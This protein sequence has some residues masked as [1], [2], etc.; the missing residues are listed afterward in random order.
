M[1]SCG[2]SDVCDDVESMDNLL[3]ILENMSLEELKAERSLERRNILPPPGPGAADTFWG[4]SSGVFV[5]SKELP[6][7][8]MFHTARYI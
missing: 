2:A 8:A 7:L 3:D 6:T 4:A 1:G 5:L